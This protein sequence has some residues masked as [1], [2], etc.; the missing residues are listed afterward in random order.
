MLVKCPWQGQRSLPKKK[1]ANELWR[2]P[3]L[4]QEWQNGPFHRRRPPSDKLGGQ[5]GTVPR[6]LSTLG[7]HALLTTLVLIWRIINT[8]QRSLCLN[9]SLNLKIMHGPWH[10]VGSAGWTVDYPYA[11]GIHFW[12]LLCPFL[13]HKHTQSLRHILLGRL[14]L[15]SSNQF[16][17][18]CIRWSKLN[19]TSLVYI[20]SIMQLTPHSWSWRS[21]CCRAS[22]CS[23]HSEPKSPR[24]LESLPP[25]SKSEFFSPQRVVL[26]SGYT[27]V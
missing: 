25:V 14:L 17:H 12:S 5:F 3:A 15:Q 7:C 16:S 13:Q 22:T 18:P 2:G 20:V 11:L 4:D 10:S 19:S 9:F 8:L 24:P 26:E 1:N 27:K 23:T 6:D 21:I